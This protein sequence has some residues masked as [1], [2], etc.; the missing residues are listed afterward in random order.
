MR[1]G[2]RAS[3]NIAEETASALAF[4]S[5]TV[6][7][8]YKQRRIAIDLRQR[9]GRHVA[10]RERQEAAGI[11]LTPVGDEDESLALVHT[12]GRAGDD[13]GLRHA[14]T[15]FPDALLQNIALI[16]LALGGLDFEMNRL[17]SGIELGEDSFLLG[18]TKKKTFHKATSRCVSSSIIGPTS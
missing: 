9:L 11:Y 18:G 1:A 7:Q 16:M 17:G 2:A 12:F 13:F 3:A 14:A 10:R 6:A 4:Q 15:R 5:G 8:R